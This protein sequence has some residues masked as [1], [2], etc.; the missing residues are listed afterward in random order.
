MSYRRIFGG[1]RF[2]SARLRRTTLQKRGAS[3]AFDRAFAVNKRVNQAR[4]ADALAL[5]ATPVF[6][7]YLP[8]FYATI[9]IVFL[10]F[11]KAENSLFG[12]LFIAWRIWILAFGFFRICC[13]GEGGGK[14][15]FHALL[16]H[17]FGR[18]CA[19]RPAG[20]FLFAGLELWEGR[21]GAAFFKEMKV[22]G[23]YGRISGGGI[24]GDLERRRIGKNRIMDWR[25]AEKIEHLGSRANAC[26]RAKHAAQDLRRA[27]LE[28][29]SGDVNI[30]RQNARH[31]RN[32]ARE[33]GTEGAVG[34]NLIRMGRPACPVGFENRV[35]SRVC[36]LRHCKNLYLCVRD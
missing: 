29:G 3:P 18:K 22:F 33:A 13:A 8:P 4:Q 32:L 19:L 15:S 17:Y 27:A 2:G 5:S 23:G 7:V 26:G 34:A 30:F 10:P 1:A 36:R 9:F 14:R 20:I 12:N 6:I 21:L 35:E 25:T 11:F 24:A 28:W 16:F 31:V